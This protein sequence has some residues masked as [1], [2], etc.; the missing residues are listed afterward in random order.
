MT[1]SL[2]EKL[3]LFFSSISS[4]PISLNASQ[5]SGSVYS[6]KKKSPEG[7]KEREAEKFG[8]SDKN[9]AHPHTKPRKNGASFHLP[10]VPFDPS[11]PCIKGGGGE[12]CGKN[13]CGMS[14]EWKEDYGAGGEW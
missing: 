5:N 6:T 2:Y 12:E 11:I 3:S 4:L 8:N 14:R 10:V 9:L 13:G 7:R 1:A